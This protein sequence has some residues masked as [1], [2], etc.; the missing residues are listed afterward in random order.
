MVRVLRP[1]GVIVILEFSKPRHFPVKQLYGLYF[2]FILPVIGKLVS[3]DGSA[4]AYLPASVKAFPDGQE[5]INILISSGLSA[6]S[7]KQLTFGIAS[8]YKGVKPSDKK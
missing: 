5:F 3:R 6:V 4:Y 7:Q 2:R 1:G 8:I